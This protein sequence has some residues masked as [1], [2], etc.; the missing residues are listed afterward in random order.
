MKNKICIVTGAN[1]GIG[2]ET[3]RALAQRQAEV[4]M[5]CRNPQKGEAALTDIQQSSGNKNVHLFIADLS[6]QASIT[7]FAEAF[8]QQFEKLDVLVNNAGVFLPRREVT[9]DGTEATF[10]INHL[11]YFQ[12]T[13]LLLD[14]LIQTPAS[15]IVNVSS[16]AHKGGGALD[17]DDLELEKGYGGYKAYAR[18]KLANILFTTELDRRLD[19]LDLETRP[20]VNCLHPGVVATSLTAGTRSFFGFIFN[21][22]SPFYLRPSKGAETSIYLASAPEVA[23]VSG[24]YFDERKAVEPRESA[25]DASAA[26]RLWEVSAAMTGLEELPPAIRKDSRRD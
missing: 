5:V 10:A 18:S 20:T 4:V 3:A 16:N 21:L 1:S 23:A 2:K 12:L 9:A 15:R 26:Q 7:G 22:F 24:Q 17:F 8:K 13:H 6:S 14:L 25:K 19:A 11:A